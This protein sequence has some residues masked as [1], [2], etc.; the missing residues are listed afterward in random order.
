[1]N[2][3]PKPTT[4][5]PPFCPPGP[6]GLRAQCGGLPQRGDFDGQRGAGLVP[7]RWGWEGGGREAGRAHSQ[8]P[9]A[10][11]SVANPKFSIARRTLNC[12]LLRLAVGFQIF[13]T[14][15]SK[16]SIAKTYS[17]IPSA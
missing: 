7:W 16:F 8:I 4:R 6:S 14:A 15:K 10:F 17:Q 5:S 9:S 13:S 1:M 11:S 12:V 3:S 2:F